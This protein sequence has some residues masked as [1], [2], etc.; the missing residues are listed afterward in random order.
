MWSRWA[1]LLAT[2]LVA[3]CA[4]IA[5]LDG[6]YTVGET[7]TRAGGTSTGSPTASPTA[8][9]TGG[10]GGSTAT[11]Q[12]GAPTASPTGT[13]GTGNAGG[14]GG[15][16]NPGG[17][18]PVQCTGTHTYDAVT[19]DCIN[20]TAPD[21]DACAGY[22]DP[23]IFVISTSEYSSGDPHHGFLRFDLDPEVAQSALASVALEVTVAG[24]SYADSDDS[25]DIWEVVPFVRSD[26]FSGAPNRVGGSAV[27]PSQGAAG[28]NQTISWPLPTSVV[29]GPSV[30][31]EMN[32]LVSN[33]TYYLDRDQSSPPQ[34]I[35]TCP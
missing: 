2:G 34:L 23:R 28:L 14:V 5:G 7:S 25:G 17:T 12:G 33:N 24:L 9:T 32:P 16:G 18:G 19:A 15:S 27:S 10:P 29:N 4:S 1:W 20:L 6:E 11:G 13:G 35:V 21:P 3:G 31:L 26:L 22:I 8:T 30:Y